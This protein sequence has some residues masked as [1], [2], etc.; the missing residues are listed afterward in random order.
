MNL[1]NDRIAQLR[2]GT[3]GTQNL[4]H[5]NNAGSSLPPDVVVDTVID[6]LRDEAITGG[7]E[8]EAKYTVQLQE[9][10]SQIA[11][12]INAD[13]SEI[14]LVENASAGWD[15]AFHGIDFK[16]G[17]EILTSEMEYVTNVLG[18]I[19]AQKY[20]GVVT[21][22]I[23]NDA[24]G[25]FDLQA[26]KAA[27]TDR[28][29]LIAVTHIASS[30]GGV[31]PAAEIGQIAREHNILYLLD[32]CQSAGHIPLDVRAIDCDMLS[33]T[34]RKYL[35]APRGTGFM[36]VKKDVQDKLKIFFHDGWAIKTLNGDHYEPRDDA[37]RFELYERNRA[38]TLGLG[39]AV[40]YA[41]ELGLDNIWQR[42]QHLSAQLRQQLSAIEDVTVTDTGSV[43][44]GIVTFTV[45]GVESTAVKAKLTEKHINV[46]VGLPMSTPYYMSKHQLSS[47]V[48]A[49]VH[50][51][52]TEEEVAIL[53]R[54]IRQMIG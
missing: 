27:I 36:Y 41:L 40:S 44:S 6:Y 47:V 51:Y 23:P 21:K 15:I 26:L 2:A 53:C 16:A 10:Y 28:T 24:D 32:A 19:D 39:K 48:R 35:R 17:D 25:N 49:S 22:V 43:Q 5:F 18:F 14:A 38:L 50:Y 9:T 1:N 12:L 33:V 45:A 11:R 8:A 13:T 37:K 42:I 3:K 54:E 29:K 20:H 31:I 52:N 46:S 4:I 34:G 30:T 7:Y